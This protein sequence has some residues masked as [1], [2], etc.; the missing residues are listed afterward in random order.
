MNRREMLAVLGAATLIP[1][2]AWAEPAHELSTTQT[3]R[4]KGSPEAVWAYVGDFAG[5]ARWL[6]VLQSSKLVLRKR[7]EV[8][9]IRE[10]VRGNGTRVREKCVEYDPLAMR[11][12]YVYADGAVMAS[13]YYST[14]DVNDAG[15]GETEV[16]WIGRFTR[17]N[18]WQDPA[19]AG[20]D[21][22]SLTALYERIYK[23]G[24]Q[25]LKSKVEGG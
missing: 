12:S 18:Y 9:A 5:I 23:A 22:A 8:G 21:D 4:I 17:V 16:I 14:I 20:Q 6:T 11:L 24:L 2:S 3:I 15:N 1:C 25:A 13:D 7:N 10:L 19:P